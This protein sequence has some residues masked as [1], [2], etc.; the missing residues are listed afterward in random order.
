MS[1]RLGL[2]L[3]SIFALSACGKSNS[4]SESKELT[5]S[6]KAAYEHY[7]KQV[8][9]LPAEAIRLSESMGVTLEDAKKA[10]HAHYAES[11]DTECADE[12]KMYQ[13]NGE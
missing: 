12:L 11:S 5:G 6:C 9:S 7:L 10:T 8:A 4:S 1:Y 2:I 13:E 3:L